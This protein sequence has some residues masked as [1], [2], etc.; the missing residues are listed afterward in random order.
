MSLL[1]RSGA[2]LGDWT[3]PEV[4][5]G[6]VEFPAVWVLLW[7]TAV[8]GSSCGGWGMCFPLFYLIVLIALNN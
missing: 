1:R 3:D 8:L 4:G 6:G 2:S 7:P 5:G